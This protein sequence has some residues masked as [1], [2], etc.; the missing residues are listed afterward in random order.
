M[1]ELAIVWMCDN[2]GED[3]TPTRERPALIVKR[4][5]WLTNA[6]Y[7]CEAC[8][9]EALPDHHPTLAVAIPGRIFSEL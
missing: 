5:K 1:T 6:C 8:K 4:R 7:C 9:R 2:C 3:F